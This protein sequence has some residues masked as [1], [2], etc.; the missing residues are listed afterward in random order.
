MTE[1]QYRQLSTIALIMGLAWIGW[2][3]FDFIQ[4]KAPGD[5]AYH[6]ASNYFADGD[7]VRALDEYQNALRENPDHQ[8]A[9]RGQAETLIMLNREAEAITLLSQLPDSA[10]T[11]ANL[12]IA[13]DRLGQ[14]EQALM[15]YQHALKLDPE[16]ASGPSWLTR[17]LRNQYEKP[18][19][20][21]ERAQ[22]LQH[23]L[24]LP[25]EQR[26]LRLPEVDQTQR[27]YKQ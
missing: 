25:P 6:A 15:H 23:Q 12:G 1:R 19:G 24:A 4:A 18:P 14:H 16:L 8:A 5:F 20:I 7:Y 9:Q 13:Y 2:M 10:G 21:A 17:F 27:P 22:Y 3:V 26:L 11:Y